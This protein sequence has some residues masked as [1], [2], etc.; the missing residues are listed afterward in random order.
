M[1]NNI[2]DIHQGKAYPYTYSAEHEPI[3]KVDPGQ[4]VRIHCVDCF[5]NLL[6]EEDQKFSDVCEYVT[7]GQPHESH[8]AYGG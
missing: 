4:T 7:S 8:P 6:V 2:L 5:E 1:S 3:A